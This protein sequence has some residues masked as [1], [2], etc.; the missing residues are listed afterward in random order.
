MT[1]IQ[2]N[3]PIDLSTIVP[4]VRQEHGRPG[5]ASAAASDG[6]LGPR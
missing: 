4:G 6:E 3:R 5:T 2:A 1:I